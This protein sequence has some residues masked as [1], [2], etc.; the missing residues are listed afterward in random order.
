MKTST[1]LKQLLLDLAGVQSGNVIALL[2]ELND[3][4][5]Q[6]LIKIHISTDSVTAAHGRTLSALRNKMYNEV[7]KRNSIGRLS[8]NHMSFKQRDF[9][10]SLGLLA[11]KKKS[12]IYDNDDL[13]RVDRLIL[14][15][16]KEGKTQAEIEILLKSLDIKPNSLSIIEKR[17]KAI[18]E[19]FGAKSNFHLAIIL[20]GK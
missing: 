12:L 16:L 14:Q 20:Y 3:Q 8:G 5:L 10:L 4:E 2:T 7:F 17:L 1:E 6:N 13:D 11:E 19:K 9:L 18:R 15:Y